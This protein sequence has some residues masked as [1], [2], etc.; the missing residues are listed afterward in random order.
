M[1]H[2]FLLGEVVFSPVIPACL[3]AFMMTTA[4]SWAL[5]RLNLYRHLWR[6]PLVEVALFCIWLGA[7]SAASPLPGTR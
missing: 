6:R 1:S 5:I 7:I 3:L 2:E 4:T